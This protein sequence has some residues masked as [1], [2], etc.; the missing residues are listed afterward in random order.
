MA[1]KIQIDPHTLTRAIERGTTKDEIVNVLTSGFDMPAKRHRKCKAKV[2]DYNQ[3][4]LG[5]FYEQKR[6]EVIYAI[7]SD[8]IITITAYVFYGNWGEQK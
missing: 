5:R 6:I 4:R 8:R 3:T 2:F 1:I 7:E